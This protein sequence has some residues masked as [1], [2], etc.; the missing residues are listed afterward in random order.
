MS[1]NKS[2]ESKNDSGQDQATRSNKSE[3]SSGS[4]E[5][6][7]E[8]PNFK[9]N[10]ESDV[11]REGV[12]P[13]VVPADFTGDP[14]KKKFA[15]ISARRSSSRSERPPELHEH[16]PTC[17]HSHGPEHVHG[18]SCKHSHDDEPHVHGPSCSHS[19]GT[20][21]HV[22]GPS[23]DHSHEHVHGPSCDHSHGPDHKHGPSCDHSHDHAHEHGSSCSH[24]HDHAHGH[25]HGHGHD[26]HH[27]GCGGHHHH[28]HHHH[29]RPR[30]LKDSR[31]GQRPAESGG[32]ACQFELDFVIPGETDE[33]GRF[34]KLE[35]I[36][37]ARDGILDIH[38]R[39]DDGRIELCVHYDSSRIPFQ[40]VIGLAQSYG[41]RI[42]KRYRQKSWF[43][44]QM[45]S[46]QCAYMIEYALNRTKGILTANVA[47]AAERLVLEYD[48]QLISPREIEAKVRALGYEVEEPE[49]GHACSFHSHGGGLAS[50]LEMPLVISSGVLL[51]LGLTSRFFIHG[52]SAETI[53]TSVFIL[54]MV[55]GGMFAVRGA[56]NSIRQGICDIET[57]MVLAG[58][59]AGL[60]GAWFEGAFLLFLFSLGHALEHRAMDKARRAVEALGK[61]RPENARVKR[62]EDVVEVP[63]REVRRGDIIVVRPGDR[64]PLDGV[65]R[66]G[67]SSLDQATI[68]GESV[69]VAKG[70]GD[71]I[72]AST[73]NTEAMLEVEVTK[74]SSESTLAKIID[75][76]S[77][78]E[79]QKGPSQRLAQKLEK[80][81]V[82]IVIVAA[83]ILS[84]VL[85]WQGHLPVKDA[86]LRGISL[87]VAASPCALAIATPAAVLAAVGRAA[88][89]GVLIKGGAH[90]ESLGKVDTIAFDKTGTLTIGKPTIMSVSTMEGVTEQDLLFWAGSAEA[91][92]SHPLA[93]AVVKGAEQRGVNLVSPQSSSAVHG[94][95]L[96]SVVQGET[97]SVGNLGLFEDAGFPP[98]L[99]VM[100]QK[101]EEAGQTIMIVKKGDQFL[102]VLGVA[103]QLRSE[104]RTV[105]ANLRKIGIKRIIMLSGDNQL[106]ASSIS[107]QVGIDETRAPLL[108]EGKVSAIKTLAKEEGGV[109]MVGDGVNDA[110]ALAVA[111]VG[112]AMGGTGSDV[113]LETADMVLMSEGLLKLP[114]AVELSR[115]ASNVIKQNMVVALGVSAVLIV[116]SIMGWVQIS[117]AVIL[118]E[119]STLVV[120]LNGLR[121]LIYKRAY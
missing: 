34:E 103:D 82:P 110:P 33:F 44:R 50:K 46:A 121:L 58:V 119:G 116:S 39:R 106:V 53:Q 117:T 107:T 97:I 92:S 77:E 31:I 23:C 94:K 115:T 51:A 37:E 41:D 18:P 102:G 8:V 76:V 113:A 24:G 95:G 65:I 73:I 112:V 14:A 69:P 96:H 9:V 26:H 20:E 17:D 64:V 81:F 57:L 1:S 111:S 109:A 66:S 5:L 19:H 6:S 72:F 48:S 29:D 40:E 22:H 67:R 61:L 32:T 56:V 25:D 78:A 88:K 13:D 120:L 89:S 108:P 87:L 43:V 52:P 28:D 36:M 11:R 70:P 27:G 98:S 45:D 7:H 47:Y 79:A 15:R 75:M 90:L 49:Q 93:E 60:L 59:G 63:V 85:W 12:V 74:L 16:G 84:F 30:N 42:S 21:A 2:R 68:T 35:E 54:A 83:P 105:L 71:T 86:V 55:C 114:F 38:V 91:H 99:P 4:E 62:G 80:T 3:P 101:L 10:A 118:H 100:V 104:A